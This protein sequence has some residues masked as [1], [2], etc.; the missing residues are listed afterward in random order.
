MYG[1]KI[2]KENK[3][4]LPLLFQQGIVRMSGLEEEERMKLLLFLLLLVPLFPP[5]L[6]QI[7]NCAPF[8][9]E[10]REDESLYSIY[11]ANEW[12]GR[13]R[14]EDTM[15]HHLLL[16]LLSP[17]PLQIT[18]CAPSDRDGRENELFFYL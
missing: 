1:L 9:G 11:R 16:P 13:R 4:H 5:P 18:N 17:P 12:I 7:T 3:R 2:K 14:T 10:G 6:F 15:K 8:D